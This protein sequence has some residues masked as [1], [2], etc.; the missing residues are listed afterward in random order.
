MNQFQS[1]EHSLQKFFYYNFTLLHQPDLN[2]SSVDRHNH[3][4][5]DQYESEQQCQQYYKQ[6]NIYLTNI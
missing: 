5:K 6:K 2:K 1:S 4:E 3:W